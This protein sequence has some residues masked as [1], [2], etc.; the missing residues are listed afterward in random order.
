[1]TSFRERYGPWALVAGASVGL[2]E[3]F[4]E[5]LAERGLH[6]LLVARRPEPL[7]SLA[8]RLRNRHSVEVRTFAVDL[9]GPELG[10]ALDRS[11]R[12]LEVGLLVYNAAH[13]VIGPFIERPLQ[14]Q[15]RVIDVNCR[16]PLVLAHRLGRAMAA[17][18]RGGILLM[19]SLAGSQ[20]GPL[21]ASYAASKAFNLV[22]AEG[23][24][25]ELGERGVDVLA[26][27]A[28]ATDTPGYAASHPRGTVALME[29]ALVVR[30]ALAAL[31]K[32]PSVVPGALNAFYA[33][34]LG[35]LLPRRT[36][37]RIMGSA[38]RRL[39]G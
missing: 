10:D 25:D 14:E 15:L 18:G 4:A 12:E 13:S 6:L 31:G 33:A 1:M 32:K 35:R 3:G 7:E 22:L 38:T 24:W 8:G 2:G 29:P 17:R 19:T 21:I 28:G 36:A 23:L 9:A 39:Y 37:V 16:G 11:I 20:G 27:R 26:C 34:L 30:E 5:A